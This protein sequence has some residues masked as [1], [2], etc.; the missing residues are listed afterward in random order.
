MHVII[1][2]MFEM[3]EMPTVTFI[4]YI[5]LQGINRREHVGQSTF[6]A[7]NDRQYLKKVAKTSRPELYHAKKYFQ[8]VRGLLKSW[9]SALSRLFN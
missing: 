9:R 6:S 1:V 3:K 8:K 2:P 4:P 7:R 5:I